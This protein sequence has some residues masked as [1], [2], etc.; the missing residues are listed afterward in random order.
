MNRRRTGSLRGS[1]SNCG[2]IAS[3][4]RRSVA[5]V[6]RSSLTGGPS[7]LH[8]LH[9]SLSLVTSAICVHGVVLIASVNFLLFIASVVSFDTVRL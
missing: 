4:V 1:V 2:D 6:R 7:H 5:I 9:I 3:I 8:H